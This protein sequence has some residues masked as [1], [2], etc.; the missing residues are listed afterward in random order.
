MSSFQV[1]HNEAAWCSSNYPFKWQKGPQHVV[2]NFRH[3]AKHI[4]EM[5]YSVTNFPF[6][7]KKKENCEKNK[8]AFLLK[9]LPRIVTIA[10]NIII[11]RVLKIVL[12]SYFLST[13]LLLLLL[14]PP[15]CLLP[16]LKLYCFQQCLKF[17][18]F[19][20]FF[21]PQIKKFC[22]EKVYWIF[23]NILL[24]EKWKVQN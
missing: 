13:L 4:L 23:K 18:V 9:E 5:E 11:K 7:W 22:K 8:R 15:H 1:Y 17:Q 20:F 19:F 21:F 14:L 3:F 2:T 10:S 12:L 16:K 6:F 24:V